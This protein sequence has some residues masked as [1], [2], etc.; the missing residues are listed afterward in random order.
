MEVRFAM[1]TRVN[2]AE[3]LALMTEGLAY[4]FCSSATCSRNGRHE[5]VTEIFAIA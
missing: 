5:G 1:E 3:D 4:R 2:R